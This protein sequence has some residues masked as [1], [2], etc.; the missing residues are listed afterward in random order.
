MWAPGVME[1]Y[2]N[3]KARKPKLKPLPS[4]TQSPSDLARVI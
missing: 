3:L 4:Q 1:A 2:T